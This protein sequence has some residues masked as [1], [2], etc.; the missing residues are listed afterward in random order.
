MTPRRELVEPNAATSL[1]RLPLAIGGRA[2]MLRGGAISNRED[3]E[4]FLERLC[5]ELNS[6]RRVR[7]QEG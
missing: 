7:L 1:R 4:K 3:Y 6:G 2:L 5:D